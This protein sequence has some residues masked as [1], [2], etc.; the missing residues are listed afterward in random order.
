MAYSELWIFLAWAGQKTSFQGLSLQEAKRGVLN[1]FL[2]ESKRNAISIGGRSRTLEITARST[3]AKN[4]E[5][6]VDKPLGLTLGPKNGGGV[7]ITV[8][9]Y[10]LSFTMFYKLLIDTKSY[11]PLAIKL[12]DS[13]KFI[14][15]LSLYIC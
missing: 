8:S 2:A 7:V 5:V 15:T 10:L 14:I 11:L 9:N 6:E 12:P 3:A 1:S 13:V 4:I